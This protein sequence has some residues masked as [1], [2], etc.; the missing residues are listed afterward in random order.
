[1]I[2]TSAAGQ[3]VELVLVRQEPRDGGCADA[4]GIGSTLRPDEHQIEAVRV[5]HGVALE[6][7][8]QLRAA[9]VLVDAADVDRERP[10][11]VELL[12]EPPRLRAFR[13]L[14]ADADDDAR[15]AAAAHALDERPF[16]ERV[17]HERPRAAKHRRRRSTGP[18]AGIAFGRRHEHRLVRHGARAVPRVVVAVAEEHEEVELGRARA[19]MCRIERRAR[20]PLAVE[21]RQ[22]VGDRMRL[23]EDELRP[24]AEVVRVRADATRGT[25]G[26]GIAVDRLLAGRQLVRQVM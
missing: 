12:P 15:T 20:R 10:R 2:S 7:R 1:M 5:H 22:F 9:L 16:L 26:R 18:T 6:V 13:N 8:E 24:A 23:V 25:G 3:R 19:S 4:S 17:V 14:R 21:P 11:D